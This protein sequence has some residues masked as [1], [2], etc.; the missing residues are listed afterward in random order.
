MYKFL[1]DAILWCNNFLY[2]IYNPVCSCLFLSVPVCSCLFL[3]VPVWSCLFLNPEFPIWHMNFFM[4][5]LL[6]C[7][8]IYIRYIILSIPVWSC[9]ILP[10]PVCPSVPVCSWYRIKKEKRRKVEE[11]KGENKGWHLKNSF[12]SPVFLLYF[13]CISPLC[14]FLF[15]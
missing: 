11:R 3:S 7:N 12:I 5:Q 6:W 2:Q 13:S 1:Y 10:D 15:L 8:N 14:I 9:L 4:I